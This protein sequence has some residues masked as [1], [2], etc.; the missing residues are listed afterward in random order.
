VTR[1]AR[2]GWIS[3]GTVLVLIA[4]AAITGVVMVRS[5]WLTETIRE[6]IVTE[7]E[8]ATG[9]K[10]EIGA[11]RVDWKTLT[12]EVDNLVI[13]G[14]EPADKAPLLAV[15]RVVIGFKIIS[16]LQR[17]FN[18]AQVE[19]DSPQAHVII[20]PDGST[21][22]PHPK[23]TSGRPAPETI[24][25]LKIGKFDLTNGVAAVER[26]GGG[27]DVTPW[28]GR[29]RNLTARI[30][31]NNAGPRYDGTVSVAPVEFV[32]NGIQTAAEVSATA[33][34]EKN[35]L[36]ISAATVKTTQSEIDLSNVLVSSFTS[37]VMTGQYR[38]RISLAEADKM[39]KLVNFQHTGTLNASGDLR[40]AS[41]TN[42]LVNGKVQGS[43]IGYG[44]VRNMRVSG[45]VSAKPDLLTISALLVNALG[46]EMRATGEIRKLEDFHLAGQ[47]EHFEARGLAALGG[48][49]RLPYDGMLSGPFDAAGKLREANLHH[50]MADATLAISP[51]QNAL[52]VRGEVMAKYDGATNTV[53][54]GQSWIALPGTRLDVS[55]VFGQRLD[56]NFQS[57]DLNDLSP[58]VNLTVLPAKLAAQDGSVVFSG[59]VTG[60][61][62]DPKIAGHA[63]ITNATY[64]KQQIDSLTGDFTAMRT[65]A[66]ATNA[67]LVSNNLRARVTGSIGLVGWKPASSSAVNGTVQLINADMGKLLA[68]AGE[69]QLPVSG[70]LNTTAQVRGTVGDP[71][72][73]AD[74]TLAKGQIYGE[75]YDSISGHAQYLNSG[76]QLLT[77]TVDAG[78]KHLNAS[79]RFDHPDKLTFNVTSNVIALNQVA[80]IKKNEPTLEGTAQLKTD[81]AIRIDRTKTHT[82]VD[83]LALNADVK[84][85]GL[86]LNARPLGDAHI[87]AETQNGVMTAK[88]DSNIAKSAIQGD[89]TVRLTGDYP[90]NARL[91]FSN[92]G[93]SGLTALLR[94][95]SKPGQTQQDLN[96]EGSAA[97][98]V[99]LNGPART[100]D[101]LTASFEVTQFELH[102][103]TVNGEARN[104]P[105]PRLPNPQLRNNGPIRA[106]LA[107]SVIRVES[108]RFQAPNTDLALSGNIALNS[109]SPFNLNVQGNM[110]LGLAEAYNADLTSSGELDVN[111]AIRGGFTNP[112]VSG[113]A[114]L[115]KAD[116]H[117]AD[118]SNG[119]TNANGVVLFS[120][121]RA[122]IQSFTAESGGGR[123]DATGFAALTNGLLAFR[124]ET[125]AQGV[126]V[127]YPEGVSS[128]SDADVTLAGT[129]DRSEVSGTVTVRRVSI[130][131]KSDMSTILAAAA[132]PAKTAQATAGF[133]TNVNLDVQIETAPD[134]AFET[135]VA[136][137]LEADANLRLRG[138]AANPAVLGRINITGGQLSFFSNKYTINQGSISFFD[139]AKI[140]P[141]LNVDLSTKARGVD[142]TLVVTGPINKLNVSYRSDPPLQFSDIVALLATGR[143]PTDP[144][145][146]IRDTGTPQSLQTL[147]ASALIG[148]AI[149]NP[150]AGRL[151][152]FFGVSNIKI[153]PQLTGITGSPEARLT[154]EQQISPE[155]LFTYITDVSST[156]TQ[157]IRVEWD[158]NRRWA[159][160]LT[161]EENGYVGI[162][163]AYKKRFK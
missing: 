9:G 61:L 32:W 15:K 94:G 42:Y 10:V 114:E 58:V 59:S 36:T 149:A 150:A 45:S 70:T 87:T 113:R 138:T 8:K 62:A 79:L 12:A 76:A 128:I 43:G 49:A 3:A 60:P 19:A 13:H 47:L 100:P 56:V 41:A 126:R 96:L 64:Q 82:Q 78:R 109:Q 110:N 11:L 38:A 83:I 98:E 154:V 75:P 105:N 163:F 140:D 152:R 132:Q 6:R 147:G 4:A 40:F 51:I 159:A 130:N 160:I 119:L 55:G 146:A 123:V 22:L 18:V 131:P 133:L 125:V 134:V 35:R 85:T 142:V 24:L 69:Q 92:L 148:E 72:A 161:R 48:I 23:T 115:K 16:F 84:T 106:S 73:T 136:Q 101:L 99:T 25:A 153:D 65:Q 108:A 50:L 112:D 5:G 57:R 90:M 86:T 111:A 63:N 157:L 155:L 145:L 102:P 118:F 135:S 104:I 81:G 156:S 139:P 29:G 121:T 143:T 107:R 80:L 1:R 93:L 21:N 144:T 30:L 28:S 122:N 88:L 137:S 14:T 141:I 67:V 162:D 158:F 52:P 97:G 2:I 74:L 26:A 127:R 95:A 53:E 20:G 120:G 71:H 7:A 46:G 117:Y 151:Q 91:T 89:G 37:P 31:Y 124:V 103:R 39:F 44:R 116:F 34:M 54:L 17:E 66:T 33:A 129:S 77:A 68:L 27:K